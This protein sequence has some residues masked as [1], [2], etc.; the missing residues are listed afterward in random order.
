MLWYM[1]VDVCTATSEYYAR[2]VLSKRM[3]LLYECC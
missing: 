2:V 3:L 1:L